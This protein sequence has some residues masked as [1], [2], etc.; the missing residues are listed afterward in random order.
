MHRE[1]NKYIISVYNTIK[2]ILFKAYAF[3]IMTVCQVHDM[4]II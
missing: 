3:V 1:I 4:H 2:L